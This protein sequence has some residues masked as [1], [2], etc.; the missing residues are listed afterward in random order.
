M[1]KLPNWKELALGGVIPQAG[2]SREKDVSGWRTY[3]PQHH[4]DLC[5]HCLRCWIFC[6]DSS[7]QVKDGKVTG[8][9]LV[10]CKGCG[11]CSQECPTKEK[12]I[13]M[14]LESEIGKE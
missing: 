5:I 6:P 12:A 14:K 4:M 11:I 10:H 8:I 1:S 2:N 13:T 3:R 9:D 7:I